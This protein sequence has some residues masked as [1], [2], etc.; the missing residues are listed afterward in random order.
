MVYDGH[1][2][3]DADVADLRPRILGREGRGSMLGLASSWVCDGRTRGALAIV[4]A[5]E[6]LDPGDEWVEVEPGKWK[7]RYACA[8]DEVT[9]ARDLAEARIAEREAEFLTL[10]RAMVGHLMNAHKVE[11]VA[12]LPHA[13]DLVRR[14]VDECALAKGISPDVAA[15]IARR[16][17]GFQV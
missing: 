15:D 3:A 4:S 5:N 14:A 16:D 6:P 7:R 11:A 9:A 2:V 1:L 10:L 8:P 13:R 17:L 12:D